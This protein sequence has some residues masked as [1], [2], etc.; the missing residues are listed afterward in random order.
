ME[1]NLKESSKIYLFGIA[2]FSYLAIISVSFL[3]GFIVENIL[4]LNE[5]TFVTSYW[6]FNGVSFFTFILLLI[7]SIK[8]IKKLKLENYFKTFVGFIIILII[9]QLLQFILTVYGF[10]IIF[11]NY[12]EKTDKY[13]ESEKNKAFYAGF[14]A[15]IEYLKYLSIGIIVFINIRKSKINSTS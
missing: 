3:I 7:L 9:S 14:Y 4:I 12:F 8:H 5:F 1:N 6:I 13:Y 11:E 10:E 15:V 2:L